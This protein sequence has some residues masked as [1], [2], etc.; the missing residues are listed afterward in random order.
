VLGL[1]DS[2][3]LLWR[4]ACHRL[5]WLFRSS[6]SSHICGSRSTCGSGVRGSSSHDA[7]TSALCP[8]LPQLAYSTPASQGVKQGKTESLLTLLTSL[9][10]RK[11]EH[12]CTRTEQR[13]VTSVKI[14]PIF[15]KGKPDQI[16]TSRSKGM[17]AQEHTS[18][19]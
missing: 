5:P 13:G 14:S 8:R 6:T 18:E 16:F 10:Y 7:T 11:I 19:N 17:Q 15:P 3:S 1:K 12:S 9:S 2:R 4:R